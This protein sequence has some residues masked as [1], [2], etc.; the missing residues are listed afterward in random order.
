MPQSG[1]V[2]ENLQQSS[3]SLFARKWLSPEGILV[4]LTVARIVQT[5]HMQLCFL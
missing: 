2:K 1:S 3:G 4:L 5:Y